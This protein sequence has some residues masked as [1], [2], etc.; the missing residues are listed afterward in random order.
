MANTPPYGTPLTTGE[1]RVLAAIAR[2]HEIQSA[3]RALG[4]S[5]DT[6]KGLSRRARRRLGASHTAHAIALAIATR[7]LPAEVARGTAPGGGEL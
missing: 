5:P 4:I 1:R 6:V 2:G 3:A 7:Q